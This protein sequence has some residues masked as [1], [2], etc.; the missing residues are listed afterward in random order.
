MNNRNPV[1]VIE[2]AHIVELV[3]RGTLSTTLKRHSA[4]D[5]LFG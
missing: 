5:N 4:D 2:Q 1:E 3:H